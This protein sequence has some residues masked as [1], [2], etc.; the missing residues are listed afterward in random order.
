MTILEYDPEYPIIEDQ[1]EMALDTD[2]LKLNETD[3]LIK[4]TDNNESK[5]IK[6]SSVPKI[7]QDL[8]NEASSTIR[9]D[10]ELVKTIHN[11]EAEDDL[12]LE[13][14]EKDMKKRQ[15]ELI[16][17]QE[18]IKR[19][20]AEIRDSNSDSDS[21]SSMSSKSTASGLSTVKM[22]VNKSEEIEADDQFLLRRFSDERL[23]SY[24]PSTNNKNLRP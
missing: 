16:K 21:D 24:I 19:L 9:S 11:K 15:E 13:D 5:S 20:E 14:F 6:R 3:S 7:S 22:A 12:K 23:D 18:D 1:T 8:F 10:E 4:L 17:R 2:D